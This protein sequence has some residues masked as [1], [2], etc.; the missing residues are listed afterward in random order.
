MK[1]A[2]VIFG[3]TAG[4]LGTL[5]T[6]C[7]ESP[8]A[9][10]PVPAQGGRIAQSSPAPAAALPT[11]APNAGEV[12]AEGR[13]ATQATGTQADPFANV[14][15]NSIDVLRRI[16]SVDERARGT[17]RKG[18]APV[19]AKTTAPVASTASAAPAAAASQAAGAT[20]G[21][22]SPA[23]S[24]A[25]TSG[26]T[27][28]RQEAPREAATGAGS[29]VAVPTS[30]PATAVPAALT[31][32]SPAGVSTAAALPASNAA[33]AAPPQQLA[34]A[35]PPA[36][37]KTPEAPQL[38]AISRPD[39]VFPREALRDGV[40]SGRIVATLAVDTEGRVTAVRIVESVPAK[41][42]DLAARRA[43]MSWRFEPI[44]QPMT[45][46]IEL[47]FKTE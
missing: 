4:A 3:L 40:L 9:Q 41:V 21:A 11:T 38:R 6:A 42:F 8:K 16:L 22:A 34:L 26:A 24:T 10:A 15:T 18:V 44:S 29:T 46:Q 33:S 35:A 13:A 7:G 36:A 25:P 37:S 12:P 19:P 14:D 5:L 30:A 39:P 28:A 2:L 45:A 47:L 43:L 27:A 31:A 20:T 17:Q 1:K 32:S 23:A